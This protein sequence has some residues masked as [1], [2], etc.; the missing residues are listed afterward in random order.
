M[1]RILVAKLA[2]LGDLLTATPALRAL[3][4]RYPRAHIAVL[5]TPGSA[6]VLTGLDSVDEVISFD[7]FAFDHPTDALGSGRVAARFA[8]RLRAGRWD[9]LALLHHLTTP[10]GVAK[11]AALAVASGAPIRAGLENGRG[12]GFLTHPVPDHGYGW[13]HEVDY[14]IDVALALGAARPTAPQ[15][16]IRPNAEDRAWATAEHARLGGRELVLLVPGSGTFST[17]RRWAAE[18]FAEVGRGLFARHGLRPVALAG[19]SDEERVLAQGVAHA[20]GDPRAIVPPAPSARALAA[21][22]ERCV[23]VVANDSGPVHLAAAVQT[24]VVAVFGPTNWR[25]WGPYPASAP[26]NQVVL[27]RVVCQP[28][29]HR[30]HEF[31]DPAGCE[32]RTCLQ[33]V[34]PDAVLQAAD[35]AIAAGSPRS[36]L[37]R[38]S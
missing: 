14:G 18:R 21:L 32:A 16:E 33:F 9:G 23:L 25:A 19:T 10:F 1:E 35:R 22:I 4:T 27:E 7:K 38:A 26:R 11:Y 3:R 13:Q 6:P 15:L 5:T 34:L 37:V 36:A 20:L 29:I 28:C 8:A 31:G 24:P 2:T 12:R 17:A 30:G